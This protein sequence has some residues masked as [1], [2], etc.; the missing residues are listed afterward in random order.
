MMLT[1]VASNYAF[2]L[3]AALLDTL[4]FYAGVRY[5]SSYLEID[6]TVEH[7]ADVEELGA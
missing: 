7:D 4:P 2:K 3:V 5:L 6:P 1:L